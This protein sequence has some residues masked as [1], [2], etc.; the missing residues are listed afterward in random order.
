[1][2]PKTTA[3]KATILNDPEKMYKLKKLKEQ[4]FRNNRYLVEISEDDYFNASVACFLH[5]TYNNDTANANNNVNN[6]IKNLMDVNFD[7]LCHDK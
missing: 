4:S 7:S 1:M 3:K 6:V 2:P 5:L